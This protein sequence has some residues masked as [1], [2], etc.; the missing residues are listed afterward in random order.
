LFG[1]SREPDE[2]GGGYRRSSA[3]WQAFPDKRLHF[4]TISE[5]RQ[6]SPLHRG[7]TYGYG[8]E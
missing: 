6:P 1:S 2:D 7:R 4:L 8:N 5:N 3:G